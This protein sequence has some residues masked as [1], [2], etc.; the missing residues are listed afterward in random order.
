MI[1]NIAIPDV[2]QKAVGNEKIEFFVKAK[3]EQPLRNILSV[4]G[5]SF[6]WILVNSLIFYGFVWELFY[7]ECASISIDGAYTEVCP[8]DLSPLRGFFIIY[9]VFLSPGI[10]V[11]LLGFFGLFKSGGYY[12][13]TENNL[14]RYSWGE[15]KSF[16][17]KEFTNEIEVFGKKDNGNIIFKLKTGVYITRNHK[18]V[19]S[20]TKINIGSILYAFEIGEYCRNRIVK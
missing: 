7:G 2:M 10:I 15:V 14:I 13:G 12:I 8:D 6:V 1:E 17:W 19:L 5:F 18:R 4:F 16:P 20:N 9:G 11:G 3:K